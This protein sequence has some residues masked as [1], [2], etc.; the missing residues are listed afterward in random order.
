MSAAIDQHR[1][2]TIA[3][4]TAPDAPDTT[5]AAHPHGTGFLH[6]PRAVW[7]IAFA[8]TVSFMG[9]GLVDPILPA[10]SRELNATPGQAMLLFTSYLFITGLA[11]FGTSWFSGRFG[12]RTTL[13]TG[14]LLIVLFAGLAS[15]SRDVAQIINLRAGWG[16]GNALF[17]STALAAIVAAAHGS[18]TGEIILFESAL[19]LGLAIGPLLGGL[20]GSVSW[21]A[22]FAGTAV[23]MGIGAL[24]IITLMRERVEAPRVEPT[25]ALRALRNPA[26]LTLA[27]SAVCYNFAFFI[28]LAYSPFPLEAAAEAHGTHIT[29]MGIGGVFFGWGL[30]VAVTSVLVAPRL[31]RTI[32][33]IP[34]LLCIYGGMAVV[35]GLLAALHSSMV[36]IIV[37]IIV[38]GLL[39]GVTNTA[40]TEAVME[41]TDLPGNVASSAYS[42]VRFIGGSFAPA[43]AGPLALSAGA[44]APYALG[45]ASMVAAGV[46]LLLGHRHLDRLKARPHLDAQSEA[47]AVAYGDR[48]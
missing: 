20:F 42:G 26:L 29:P 36:A 25:A 39:L 37:L 31:T 14:L 22:P 48:V 24:G 47:T 13:I 19:G 1:P 6:Q 28:L 43:V 9:I 34:T 40:L 10:I 23:L 16:L 46:A 38:G 7:E 17:I 41:A 4:T 11:M 15:V 32:G 27:A 3:G 2:D 5:A 12:V 33:L 30:S 44:F 45:A 35:L 18:T 21:R 8:T